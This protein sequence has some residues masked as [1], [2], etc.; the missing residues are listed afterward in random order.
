[1]EIISISA[2][3][4]WWLFDGTLYSACHYHGW[5]TSV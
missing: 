1:M 3:Q 2:V 5:Q 4:S